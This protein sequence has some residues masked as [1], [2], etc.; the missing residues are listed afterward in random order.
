MACMY[1]SRCELGIVTSCNV[2]SY[3]TKAPPIMSN[4]ITLMAGES[5]ALVEA[6]SDNRVIKDTEGQSTQACNVLAPCD[7]RKGVYR[8][9]TLFFVCLA[10]FGQNML[11]SACQQLSSV[12]S[13]K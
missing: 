8:F 13:S 10:T 4:C 3:S 9:L 11:V 12:L 7:P 1:A 2:G 5:V 6:A